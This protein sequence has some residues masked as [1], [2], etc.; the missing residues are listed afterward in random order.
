MIGLSILHGQE[1][2]SYYYSVD[3]VTASGKQQSYTSPD[4]QEIDS[5][6]NALNEAIVNG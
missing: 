4:K 3:N 6:V 1:E 2:V 5:I